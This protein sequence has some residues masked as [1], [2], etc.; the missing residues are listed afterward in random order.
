MEIEYIKHF[1]FPFTLSGL[2]FAAPS[3]AQFMRKYN[4]IEDKYLRLFDDGKLGEGKN[5]EKTE[6]QYKYWLF[7]STLTSR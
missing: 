5:P 2:F 7:E 1:V 3:W 4:Q 6:F